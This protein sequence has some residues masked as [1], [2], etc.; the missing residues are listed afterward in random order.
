MAA[1]SKILFRDIHATFGVPNSPQSVDISQNSDG[2]ISNFW[3]SGQ[4]LTKKDCHNSRTGDDIDM[5]LQ[6]VTK[7][8]KKNNT[9]SKNT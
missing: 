3:I 1:F 7:L 2:G 9:T 8:N 6:P 4:S 5:K